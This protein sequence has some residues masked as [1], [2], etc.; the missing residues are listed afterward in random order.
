MKMIEGGV[1]AAQGFVA[2]GIHCGIRKNKSK[3]DL[4]M[5]YSEK[6]CAAA[7]V[8]TQNLVK[9]APILVTRKNIADGA[10][11]AVICNSGN[12]NTCNADGEEKAQAMCDLT[13]QALGIAPPG[14]GGGFHRGYRP[15]AAHRAHRKFRGGPNVGS[16]QGGRHRRR[17]GH[18]DYRYR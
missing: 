14:R 9:G 4:A 7:A 2:G 11:K 16:L 15:G 3:P 10:A 12:A 5:I 13:A 1:T 18:H 8:Y 6:P 17:G